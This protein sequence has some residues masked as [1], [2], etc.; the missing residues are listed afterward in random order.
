MLAVTETLKGIS[1]PLV[2]A[3]YHKIDFSADEKHPTDV[4]VIETNFSHEKVEDE[5][6]DICLMELLIDLP[7]LQHQAESQIGKFD[8]VDI[9]S[10]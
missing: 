9:R 5:D 3:M 1:H 8:R 4:L 10:A 7:N 2:D 6:F